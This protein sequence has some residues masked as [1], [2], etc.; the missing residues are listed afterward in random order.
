MNVQDYDPYVRVRTYVYSVFLNSHSSEYDYW[1]IAPMV[2]QIHE[3]LEILFLIKYTSDGEFYPT[4][5]FILKRLGLSK[6]S[7][8]DYFRSYISTNIY[9]CD[10]FR[11]RYWQFWTHLDFVL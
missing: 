6:S 11:Y 1:R 10:G 8:L 5:F 7:S 3:I 9:R 4:C 2:Y